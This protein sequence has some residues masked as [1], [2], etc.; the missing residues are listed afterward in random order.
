M[1]WVSL[2]A[3]KLT[4]GDRREIWELLCRL[5]SRQRIA[6]LHWCCR[7]APRFGSAGV[8]VTKHT[9]TANEALMDLYQLEILYGLDIEKAAL[10][11]IRRVRRV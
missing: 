11:L 6:F 7:K 2:T 8:R 1:L 5:N 4:L 9:G 3:A 10:E